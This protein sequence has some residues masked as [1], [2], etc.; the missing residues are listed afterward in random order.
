M[1]ASVASCFLEDFTDK[2]GEALSAT[3]KV[4]CIVIKRIHLALKVEATLFS[5]R[6]G[7]FLCCQCGT[8]NN[9]CFSYV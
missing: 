2:L 1:T 3:R 5:Y 6:R 8:T 9:L 7:S 4:R